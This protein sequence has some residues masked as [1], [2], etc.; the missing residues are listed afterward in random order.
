MKENQSIKIERLTIDMRD[1]SA[2]CKA[3]GFA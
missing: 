1:A 2:S 3:G